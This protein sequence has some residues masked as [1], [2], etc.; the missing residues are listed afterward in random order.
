VRCT[1]LSVSF[2][3]PMKAQLTPALKRTPQ[4]IDTH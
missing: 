1:V 3:A 2:L 4:V